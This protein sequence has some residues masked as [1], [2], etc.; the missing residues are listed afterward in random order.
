MLW[1][2]KH[3]KNTH[4]AK[5]QAQFLDAACTYLKQ[6]IDDSAGRLAKYEKASANKVT[7]VKTVPNR[8]ATESR[9]I[10]LLIVT[11]NLLAS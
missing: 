2:V 3:L 6:E 4:K 11:L 7:C 5:W 10:M 9:I 8:C 1:H